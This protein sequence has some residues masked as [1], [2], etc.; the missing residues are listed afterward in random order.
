MRLNLPCCLGSWLFVLLLSQMV[1]AG[2]EWPQFRGPD[3]QGHSD[4]VGLP[5]TWS[6]TENI[7]WKTPLPGKGWSSPVV[8]DG[9]I[10][11]TTAIE[12][13]LTEEQRKERLAKDPFAS[14]LALAAHLSLRAIC[15]DFKS[16]KILF[17]KELFSHDNPDPIH[18]TNSYASPTAILDAGR[19]YC[20]FGNYGTA[21]LDA[22]SGSIIWQTRLPLQHNV[23]PGS[24]PVLVD[25]LLV[26][27]CDGVD[28]QYVT[29]LDAET[30]EEAWKVDRPPFDGGDGDHH[31]AFC[32]PL[33][34]EVAGKKQVISCGAQR[35]IA[36]EPQT[37]R[38]I[39]QVDYGKGFSNVPRPVFGNGMVYICTGFMDHQLWALRPDG[40]GNVT[41]THVVWKQDKQI[42]DQPSPIL[43]G[44]EIYVVSAKGIVSCFDA[45]TGEII[46]RERVKGN[47]TASPTFADGHLFFCSVEGTTT[48][49]EP[50]REFKSLASNQLEGRLQASPAIVGKSILLRTDGNLYRIESLPMTSAS[51]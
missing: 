28:K 46:W 30:G 11:L 9:R 21:C 40:E 48:L 14:Q 10:W 8:A 3:G 37:G 5:V 25:K 42:P 1:K 50:G 26:L 32:T 2:D 22:T 23:G 19:L 34:I 51:K 13:L 31:K 49:L 29:A 44:N 20:H 38:S 12:T 45:L 24:S 4:A 7:V 41:D 16:G 15:I 17:D 6:E 36:Y 35:V 47:Y 33:V 18:L 27:N 39:W 43:V